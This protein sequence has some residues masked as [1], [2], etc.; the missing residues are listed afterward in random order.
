MKKILLLTA[1]SLL[2]FV[3][4]SAIAVPVRGLYEARVP[5]ADQSA[6]L[7]DQALQQALA[8]VLVRVTGSRSLPGA[9]PLLAR[10]ATLVQGY[11]YET[12]TPGQGLLLK[13]QFDARAVDALLRQQGLPVWGP[14]RLSHQVWL[15]LRDDGA[16]R[17]VLDQAAAAARAEALLIA[18][19]QRGLPLT[20][21]Q[22]DATDRQLVGFNELW[23]GGTEDVRGAA[24]RYDARRILIGR[25]GREGGRWLGRW[26][27]LADELGEEWTTTAATLEEVL[28]EG[29]HQLADREGRRFA[30]QPGLDRDLRLQVAGVTSLQDYGRALNYLRGL[31]PVR[32]A[33]VEAAQDN[34]VTFR[35]S[36][37]GD[38]DALTRVI[39]AGRVL[40]KEENGLFESANRY[41]LVR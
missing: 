24:R 34:T 28:A 8:A 15:A 36:V 14:N 7:R 6:A 31:N 40:R 16:A 1:A 18:A 11:G 33:Q 39:A 17:A 22:M 13:A 29:V 10:A 25:V 2:A 27:L 38:P 32:S 19:E 20:F 41:V 9:E 5:V 37:E 21:P 30:T 12:G 35:L 4:A 26:T 3:A 23:S